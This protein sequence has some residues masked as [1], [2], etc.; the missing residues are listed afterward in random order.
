[1]ISEDQ[2]AF[3]LTHVSQGILYQDQRSMWCGCLGLYLGGESAICT[4]G[5]M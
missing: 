1:M 3:F 5:L 2:M 4:G